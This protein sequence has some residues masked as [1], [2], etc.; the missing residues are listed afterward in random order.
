MPAAAYGVRE[1]VP[2]LGRCVRPLPRSIFEG[3]GLGF[4]RV[5]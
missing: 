4:T 3:K 5:F 2:Y 1:V